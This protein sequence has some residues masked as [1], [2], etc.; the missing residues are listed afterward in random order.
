MKRWL[1]DLVWR[2]EGA[3][4]GLEWA[5]VAQVLVLGSIFVLLAVRGALAGN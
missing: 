2:E 1:M 5:L 4:T 3:S